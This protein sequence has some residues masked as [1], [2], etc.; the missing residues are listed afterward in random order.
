MT[1]RRAGGGAQGHP[2]PI[3]VPALTGREPN[4]AG[5]I[6]CPFHEDWNPC[7][8]VYPTPEQGWTCFQCDGDQ[9][10]LVGGTIIDLG[11]R[12]YRM[13]PRREYPALLRRLAEELLR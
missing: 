3:Y 8:H 1:P 6:A 11:A 2:P 7:F 4:R 13:D 12:L 9:G 10:R 5:K